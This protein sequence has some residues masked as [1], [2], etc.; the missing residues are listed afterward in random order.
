MIKL[1]VGGTW[2]DHVESP[3]VTWC[4]SAVQGGLQLP[5]GKVFLAQAML[6]LW[7]LGAGTAV[8]PSETPHMFLVIGCP[9]YGWGLRMICIRYTWKMTVTT[10]EWVHLGMV[11][12]AEAGESIASAPA[13]SP[14]RRLLDC[15]PAAF[16]PSHGSP[17]WTQRLV[18]SRGPLPRAGK[19]PYLAVKPWEPINK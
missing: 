16:R 1:G 5:T 6:K 19:S 11:A 8:A 12:R 2:L 4:R 10:I 13:W 17:L 18:Q 7:K 14:G 9:L 15:K 3:T